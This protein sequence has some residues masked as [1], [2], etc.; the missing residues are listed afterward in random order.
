MTR[1]VDDS[2]EGRSVPVSTVGVGKMA[3]LTTDGVT[4]R[5]YLRM[6]IDD[7]LLDVMLHP[8]VAAAVASQIHRL[9]NRSTSGTM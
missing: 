7:E 9:T 6:E 3:T 2:G 5:V 1:G 8:D 4:S